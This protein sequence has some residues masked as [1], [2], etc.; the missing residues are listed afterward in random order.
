[1]VQLAM[2]VIKK[3]KFYVLVLLLFTSCSNR[4]H[5]DSYSVSIHYQYA[6]FKI[7]KNQSYNIYVENFF[8]IKNNTND[9]LIV[10]YKDIEEN[11]SIKY[12]NSSRKSFSFMSTNDLKI[13]PLDS[14]DLNC[15]VD[16]KDV[17]K[18][19]PLKV[20]KNDYRV[21]DNSTK[22]YLPNSSDYE[23]MRTTKFGVFK[24]KYLK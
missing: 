15:A 16:V 8:N 14:I 6:V 19:I 21:Y 11:L 1:M 23:I 24:E 9:T 20:D 17:I 10:P 3:N 7:N 4:K 18:K 22:K 12:K 2:E 5:L 13:A